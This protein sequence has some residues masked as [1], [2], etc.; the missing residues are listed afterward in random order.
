MTVIAQ[1]VD[2]DGV[3][4]FDF[5]DPTGATNQYGLKTSPRDWAVDLGAPDPALTVIE[6][7]TRDGGE[8]VRTRSRLTSGVITLRAEATTPA[9]LLAGLGVLARVLA[10]GD[11]RLKWSIDGTN[12][13]Y[14]R[15]EP[16]PYL[17]LHLGERL[18]VFHSSE[19][20]RAVELDVRFNR[21]PHYELAE[22]D[23]TV[24]V[25]KNPGLLHD[26]ATPSGRPDQW[27][28]DSTVGISAESIDA[29]DEAYKFIIADA[30]A[31]NLQ[32][33]SAAATAAPGDVWTGSCY[34]RVTAVA[35]GPKARCV[36]RFLDNTG[37]PI[38]SDYSGTLTALTTSWQRLT[39]TTGA[40]PAS[41]DRVRISLQVDN[42]DATSV[43]MEFR[44][45]QLEKASSASDFRTG[46]ETV[47]FD[48]SSTGLPRKVMVWCDGD[49]SSLAKCRL[50]SDANGLKAVRLYRESLIPVDLLKT[51]L[52]KEWEDGTLGADSSSVADVEAV[53]DDALQVAFNPANPSIADD[54]GIGG[55]GNTIT[56]TKPSGLALGKV[57]VVGIMRA[58]HT[59]VI[60]AEEGWKEIG[61]QENDTNTYGTTVVQYAWA[62]VVTEADLDD[63]VTD[64][65][66][67]VIHDAAGAR[68]YRAWIGVL[69][70]VDTVRPIDVTKPS[71]ESA[72]SVPTATG[73]TTT[74]NNEYVL[75]FCGAL[76]NTGSLSFTAP[77]GTT[78]TYTELE[79]G[80]ADVTYRGMGVFGGLMSTAGATGNEDITASIAVDA[81]MVM[82][83]FRKAPAAIA[84][85]SKITFTSLPARD[86]DVWV[87]C[88]PT[89]EGTLRLR[90]EYALQASPS[91]WIP[92]PDVILDSD[93]ASTFA[94]VDVLFGR[95]RIPEDYALNTLSLRLLAGQETTGANLRADYVFLAP[96][97]E[98]VATMVSP[99][100]LANG[101]H[102]EGNAD[103]DRVYHL[104]S[105]AELME[106][107]TTEGPTPIELEPGWNLLIPIAQQSKATGFD[108][109]ATDIDATQ[110]IRVTHTPRRRIA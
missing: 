79:D 73:I 72:S 62:K 68:S 105:A 49:V 60:S 6:P 20:S 95:I 31:H 74:E 84:E 12:V 42:D 24:N 8:I 10:E 45:A 35:G 29:D 26:F 51:T 82:V 15:L 59:T 87:R 25:L 69:S 100:L 16:S 63:D 64:Y 34:A 78:P 93:G 9:N 96:A 61:R 22:L 67:T 66:F 108:Y 37:T 107:G 89:A 98:H 11:R 40:A 58:D 28:W 110:T 90:V 86:Y 109:R 50:T 85:R 65:T 104:S 75:L 57:M 13:V 102:L 14:I 94:Y 70:N 71:E 55:T 81:A 1:I 88:Y 7:Q 41:T 54:P 38:G 83:A 97:S 3:L 48:P 4:E 91:T 30:A 53:G 52:Y 32:Q 92:L 5:N 47:A 101:E 46:P 44:R 43:T 76:S 56:L 106:I 19:Y 39:V 36:L 99:T 23:P 77:A 80:T 17:A 21:Q 27:T 2:D 103:T 18:G 33:S